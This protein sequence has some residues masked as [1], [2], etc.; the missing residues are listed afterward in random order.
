MTPPEGRPL[1]LGSVGE[2]V[3]E[4]HRRLG[5]LGHVVAD[6]ELARQ[7][8]GD[9]TEAAVRRLQA[10][11]GI[12]P[13]GTV[14]E[15]TLA[16]LGLRAGPVGVRP[17]DPVAGGKD[18][19]SGGS[20][21]GPGEEGGPPDGGAEPPNGGHTPPE[22]Q[23]LV[24]GDVRYKGGLPI[25]GVGVVAVDK[26][27]RTESVLG[28]ATTDAQGAFEIYYSLDGVARKE[29]RSPDLVVR[30]YR[31]VGGTQPNQEEP[32]AESRVIFK[33]Q[34]IVKVRL[35]VDGGPERT[36]SEYEQLT[37][38]LEPLLDGVAIGD[39]VEDDEQHDV[40]LLAGKTGQPLDRVAALVVSHKLAAKT[41]LPPEVFYGLVRQQQPTNLAELLAVDPSVQRQALSAAIAAGT[42]P[43]RLHDQLDDVQ[44]GL[45]REAARYAGATQAANGT[46]PLGAV[47]GTVLDEQLVGSFLHEYVS[48]KGSIKDF[49]HALA[50]KPELGDAVPRVQTTLQLA[51]LTGNHLP[52]VRTL[53]Q[54]QERGEFSSLA[55]LARFTEDDWKE[56]VTRPDVPEEQ[57]FP[58]SIPGSSKDEKAALG[59]TQRLFKATTVYGEQKALV[60]AGLDSSLAI[61]RLS[62]GV[63]VQRFSDTPMSTERA[64]LVY[65]K[66][67]SVAATALNLAAT[68]SPSF[69]RTPMTVVKP[70]AK[71]DIPDLETL[72]GS[73]SLCECEDCRAIDSP[74]AY[75]A[76]MLAFLKERKQQQT[77]ARDI[78]FARRPDLGELELTCANPN[79]PLPYVD[80]V[81]ELL[82]NAIAPFA[83]FDLP[84]V[85]A[86]ELDG[87]T[88]SQTLRTAFAGHG[89][90]LAPASVVVVMKP[91][92]RWFVTDHSTLYP[93]LKQGGGAPRVLALAYQTGKSAEE[94]RASPEH[95]NP[96]AYAALRAALYPW[97]LPFDLWW[98]EAQTYL[99]H[100]GVQRH[101]LMAE[102]SPLDRSAA[103][104]DLGIASEYL[105]L[106]RVEQELVT[107]GLRARV[108][109][110]GNL[111]ARSGT[112]AIDGVA[113]ANGDVVLVKDQ[114]DA[115]E[116]GLYVVQ[117]G[118]WT[119]FSEAG[120]SDVVAV[121]EGATN[122][123]TTW[124]V[125]PVAAGVQATAVGPWQLWGLQQVGNQIA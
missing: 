99:G 87:A 101:E 56:I 97:S 77:N 121:V 62:Q 109:T 50:E 30:A 107:G 83:P 96:A 19:G 8:F 90:A 17:A 55:E 81:N 60:D 48:S 33:A 111:P 37:S 117:G 71:Q 76:E 42:I 115:T 100:L 15:P 34:R 122:A 123:A 24:R 25:E 112:P 57:L 54:M 26:E 86:A 18:E 98:E 53:Q 106:T 7:R 14:D 11:A 22:F 40:T 4:L 103:L 35:L 108:A 68:Y 2:A 5:E 27:L 64:M 38:E 114:A 80:L 93:I 59:V 65:K 88:I 89:I 51:V 43:G 104:K 49:W 120:E 74:A 84:N 44:A 102:F 47:L 52:L 23:F 31:S 13:T 32:L 78:L 61:A 116:N 10:E 41:D 92:E 28:L 85:V 124:L 63:F 91:G 9:T 79:T 119:P 75:L 39:L 105:G 110:T 70:P 45:R 29:K 125:R 16:L 12:E 6:D 58:P 69:N 72:F 21:N 113:T 20:G 94:L 67:A 46:T 66:A 3:S 118:A 1:S 36:W 73:V 82:E 95:A